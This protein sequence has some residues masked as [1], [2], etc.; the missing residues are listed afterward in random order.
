MHCA[1]VPNTGVQI[2]D[3]IFNLHVSDLEKGF[4]T[5]LIDVNAVDVDNIVVES[6]GTVEIEF[7]DV[8]VYGSCA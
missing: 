1:F 6:D 4:I 2:P 7:D 5:N 3:L 8:G